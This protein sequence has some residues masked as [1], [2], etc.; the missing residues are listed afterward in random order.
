M[1]S[2][3][4]TNWKEHAW[5]LTSQKKSVPVSLAPLLALGSKAAQ[6]ELISAVCL[7]VE[8]S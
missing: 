2:D 8:A 4:E 3:R 6:K 1:K 5:R 7:A